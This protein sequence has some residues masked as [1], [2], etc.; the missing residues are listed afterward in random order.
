MLCN[1]EYIS[2]CFKETGGE[3]QVLHLA[4]MPCMGA[5]PAE[6]A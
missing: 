2:R 6:Y 3:R 5:Y 4:A 1:E